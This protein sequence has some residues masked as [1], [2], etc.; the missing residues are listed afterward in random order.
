MKENRN[1]EGVRGMAAQSNGINPRR[2]DDDD[3][4][5]EMSLTPSTRW[6]VTID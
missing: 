4:D 5:D 6:P 2:D 1:G 3:D